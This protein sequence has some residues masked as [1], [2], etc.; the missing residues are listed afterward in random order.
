MIETLGESKGALYKGLD[1]I[2]RSRSSLGHLFCTIKV[3]MV[4]TY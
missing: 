3:L 4:S 1:T 2:P